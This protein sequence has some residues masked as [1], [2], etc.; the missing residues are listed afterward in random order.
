MSAETDAAARGVMFITEPDG[1]ERFLNPK[2]CQVIEAG[3]LY[4]AG[5]GYEIF[6]CNDPGDELRARLAAAK[7][8][9]DKS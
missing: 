7:A 2:Y 3:I 5:Y 6:P 8:Q 9:K 1:L 4:D